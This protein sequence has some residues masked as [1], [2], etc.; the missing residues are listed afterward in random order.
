MSKE[1]LWLVERIYSLLH[2][3]DSVEVKLDKNGK[4]IVYAVQKKKFMAE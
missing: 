4:I 2:K 3:G 1:E